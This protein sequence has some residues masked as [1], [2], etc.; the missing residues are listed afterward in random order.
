MKSIIIATPG[1]LDIEGRIAPVAPGW[2]LDGEPITRSW[3][4]LTSQD[5]TSDVCVWECTAG[6][7]EW[8][9]DQDEAVV[10]VGGEVFITDMNGEQRRLGQGDLAFF[11][12]GTSC[13]WHV[14]ERVRKIAVLREPMWRP[15]G[16]GL[17]IW[18]GLVRRCAKRYDGLAP[19]GLAILSLVFEPSMTGVDALAAVTGI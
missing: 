14:P 9:Y 2:V 7:F 1:H 4:V 13:V 17:K 11:P 19:F 8:H 10:I 5:L 12:A 18:K 16:L 15:M 6:R 3:R